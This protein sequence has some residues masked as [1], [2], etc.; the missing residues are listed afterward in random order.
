MT[1]QP[2]LAEASQSTMNPMLTTADVAELLAV[3]EAW[4]R[5]RCAEGEIP[6]HKIGR[7]WRI[8]EGELKAWLDR[9]RFVPD[10]LPTFEPS[11]PNPPMRGSLNDL[12]ERRTKRSS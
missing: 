5:E 11:T 10:V 9:Q 6:A 12:L 3:T 2:T 1:S 7:H 8:D 4:V